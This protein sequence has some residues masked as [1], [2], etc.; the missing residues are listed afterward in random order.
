MIVYGHGPHIYH[1]RYLMNAFP[2]L[3]STSSVTLPL[4]GHLEAVLKYSFSHKGM[5]FKEVTSH[6]NVLCFLTHSLRVEPYVYMV[7]YSSQGH[8]F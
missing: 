6:V 4:K 5:F 8:I 3:K 7:I 1:P 2:T